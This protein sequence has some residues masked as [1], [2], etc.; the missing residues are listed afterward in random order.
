[1]KLY[2]DP[3]TV[4]CR[5]VIAGLDMIGADYAEQRLDFFAGDH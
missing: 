2:Y 3:I 5:K 4:N 1:M